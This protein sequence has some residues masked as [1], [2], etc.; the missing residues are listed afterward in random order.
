MSKEAVRNVITINLELRWHYTPYPE[1][2]KYLEA[3]RILFAVMV[4]GYDIM[5]STIVALIQDIHFTA[6]NLN[7][8]D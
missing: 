3:S 4:V 8:M 2:I 6:T 1:L 7:K 5:A